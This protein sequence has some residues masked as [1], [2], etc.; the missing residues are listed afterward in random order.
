LISQTD[1]SANITDGANGSYNEA[2]LSLIIEFIYTV[3]ANTVTY[4]TETN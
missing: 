4:T 1:F 2:E 3:S